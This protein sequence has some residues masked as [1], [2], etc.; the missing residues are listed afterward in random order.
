VRFRKRSRKPSPVNHLS[1]RVNLVAGSP[2]SMWPVGWVRRGLSAE[3]QR[4]RRKRRNPPRDSRRI[5]V[6]GYAPLALTRPTRS[7]GRDTMGFTSFNPFYVLWG[8]TLPHLWGVFSRDLVVSERSPGGAHET[9]G[10]LSIVPGVRFAPP[11]LLA[12]F[13]PSYGLRAQAVEPC[14]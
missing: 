5:A 4:R 7:A 6:V 12:S 13:N 11:G 3:A 14:L 8:K 1:Q 10:S 9:R 2:Q